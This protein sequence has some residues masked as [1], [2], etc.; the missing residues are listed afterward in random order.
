MS[1]YDDAP[2]GE[3]IDEIN[4]ELTE[5][6][7]LQKIAASAP[8]EF[9]AVQAYDVLISKLRVHIRSRSMKYRD[10]ADDIK[11]LDDIKFKHRNDVLEM[12]KSMPRMKDWEIPVFM[13]VG[14]D[15][16][17]KFVAPSQGYGQAME[18]ALMLAYARLREKKIA[19][20][21]E[22]MEIISDEFDLNRNLAH[23]YFDEGTLDRMIMDRT[24]DG[25]DDGE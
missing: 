9:M 7:K 14:N 6:I 4:S 11:K 20:Y 19:E 18:V 2:Q 25:D 10:Y 24:D 12:P 22:L 23:D 16:S 1:E 15:P 3:Q 13:Q 17:T 5:I 21:N 8:T